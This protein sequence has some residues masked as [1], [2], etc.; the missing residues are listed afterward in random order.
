MLENERE[1]NKEDENWRERKKRIKKQ[2]SL[3]HVSSSLF[4]FWLPF[5]LAG[6]TMSRDLTNR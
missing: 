2:S 4:P 3:F 1:K 5:S 6:L